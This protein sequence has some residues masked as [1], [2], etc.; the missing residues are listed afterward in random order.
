MQPD[1]INKTLIIVFTL[2]GGDTKD[3]FDHLPKSKSFGPNDKQLD[4]NYPLV[5]IEETGATPVN[6]LR[7]NAT[8]IVSNTV[9]TLVKD[10][11]ELTQNSR[12]ILNELI[13]QY[14]AVYVVYHSGS[15]HG[16]SHKKFIQTVKDKD[17]SVID[18][19]HTQGSVFE[20]L[21]K[22]AQSFKVKQ[23]ERKQELYSKGVTEIL[24]SFPDS[25]LE[26]KLEL[27][28]MCLTPEGS[29]KALK[30][31]FPKELE[32]ER[33]K[34]W[35]NK[36]DGYDNWTIDQIVKALAGQPE[37][38]KSIAFNDCFDPKYRGALEALRDALIP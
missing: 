10:D 4:A 15:T 24:D 23:N 22:I 38:N 26:A 20:A 30:G 29:R 8:T 19:H 18:Q 2:N 34:F 21:K 16:A 11:Q 32:S 9:I 17:I 35:Q 5:I 28:H 13:N 1:Q 3:I 33:Q 37:K 25:L 14:S 27:L 36:V 6:Q 7:D 12:K 31:E